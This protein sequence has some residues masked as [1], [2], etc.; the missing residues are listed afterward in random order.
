MAASLVSPGMRLLVVT[1]KMS[2]PSSSHLILTLIILSEINSMLSPAEVIM[3]LS[4]VAANWLPLANPIIRK[5]KVAGQM[6]RKMD[7]RLSMINMGCT[8]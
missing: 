6:L 7:T 3:A 4:L 8:H 2:M 5:L 1:N